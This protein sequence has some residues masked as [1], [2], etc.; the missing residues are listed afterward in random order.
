MNPSNRSPRRRQHMQPG[1]ELLES[2]E[3]LTT[4]AGNTFAI[5]P[6]TVT[7]PG[8]TVS[9][10][11]T[12]DPAHFT[13][14]QGKVAMGI[15]V[16]PDP[17]GTL[18]PLIA[19]VTNPHD[20][21]VAQTFHSIYD[22]HLKHREVANG[23]GTSAVIS[24]L[25]SFPSNPTGPVT[26]KVQV[27]AVSKSSGSFLLGFYL[28]GDANGDGSVDKTDLKIVKAERGARAGDAR[29]TFDADANRDGRIGLIDVAYAQQ[30]QGIKTNVSPVV[31]ANLDP[32]SV[33]MPSTRSTVNPTA[34]F[35]G[36]ATPGATVT[37]TNTSAPGSAPVTTTADASGKYAVVTPLVP[38]QNIFQVRSVDA[39]GQTISGKIG[40][41]TLLTNP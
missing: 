19:A 27:Q 6:G 34:R 32:N 23:Q 41:V 33:T 38:G 21:V 24:P 13:R 1:A 28:P 9:V 2:R 15:D 8:D 3:L 25:G 17:S 10:S 22:P 16:V 7:K 20:E 12:L 18:K 30:N 26:Y 40:A 11:F 37:Y 36:T 39:F 5:L 29:Y 4:G 14:P 35:T 31:G